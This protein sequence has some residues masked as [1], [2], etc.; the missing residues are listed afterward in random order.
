MIK[1]N[2]IWGRLGEYAPTK[3]R[4]LQRSILCRFSIFYCGC[5]QPKSVHILKI[6]AKLRISAHSTK[7]K[8]GKMAFINK[9]IYYSGA[10]YSQTQITGGLEPPQ[11]YFH[12]HKAAHPI[13][14]APLVF[15]RQALSGERM[16]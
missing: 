4:L 12:R 1:I 14:G 5:K 16:T 3:H 6:A 11:L 10:H 2:N 13:R 7:R 8:S 15:S 9:D